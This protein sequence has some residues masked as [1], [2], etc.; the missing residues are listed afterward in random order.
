MR[1]AKITQL[2]PAMVGTTIVPSYFAQSIQTRTGASRR[3]TAANPLVSRVSRRF[4]S[5]RGSRDGWTTVR[6]A[7][8]VRPAESKMSKRTPLAR[9]TD[10]RQNASA[11]A[12]ES[13][14][15]QVTASAEGNSAPLASH[16]RPRL[17]LRRERDELTGPDDL[18]PVC[19]A[20]FGVV[21]T[22]A[23]HSASA[24]FNHR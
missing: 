23:L 18:A 20:A 19:G 12:N 3:R 6:S 17:Q 15:V 13:K 8:E 16:A 2:I 1:A 9:S 14:I 10:S 24:G 4:P 5:R 22:N 11:V 21:E 7:G